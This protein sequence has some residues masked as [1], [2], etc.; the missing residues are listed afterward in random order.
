MPSH[1]RPAS[2]RQPLTL[3]VWPAH[4]IAPG[5][6]YLIVIERSGSGFGAYVPD[7]PGCT[8]MAS[9]ARE[10][11]ELIRKRVAQTLA[12]SERRGE[13]IPRAT[14]SA[15]YFCDSDLAGLLGSTATSR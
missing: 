3:P 13:P 4:C 9:T 5:V 14:A 2:L 12:C 1:A 15:E 10:V 11:K 8:A 7:L 6:R